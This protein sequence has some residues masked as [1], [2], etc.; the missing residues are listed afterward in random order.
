MQDP[1]ILDLLTMAEC[2]AEQLPKE[3]M[4]SRTETNNNNTFYQNLVN[5]SGLMQSLEKYNKARFFDEKEN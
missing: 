2:I 5:K 3:L 4:S 1:N